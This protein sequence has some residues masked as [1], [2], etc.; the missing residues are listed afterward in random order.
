MSFV[1]YVFVYPWKPTVAMLNGKK[2]RINLRR[3]DMFNHQ[4][5]L[6]SQKLDSRLLVV[7]ALASS[8]GCNAKETI[9]PAAPDSVAIFGDSVMVLGDSV[10]LT[11]VLRKNGV[12]LAGSVKWQSDQYEIA[13][14]SDAGIVHSKARGLATISATSGTVRGQVR[15]R[16]LGVKAVSIDPSA[17]DLALGWPVT[18]SGRVDTDSGVPIKLEWKSSNTTTVVVTQSGVVTAVTPGVSYVTASAYGVS[19]SSTITV[20]SIPPL[21]FG[22]GDA[23]FALVPPG[24]FQMGGTLRTGE[25]PIRSVV[26]TRGLSV[27]RTEVTQA[28]WL[29]VMGFNPSPYRACGITC[30][31]TGISWQVAQTFI[32]R[33]NAREPGANYR[34]PTEAEWEYAARA[35]SVGDFGGSGTVSEMGWTS[36]NS[37]GLPKPAALKS[38]NGWGL[39]DMHG[40]AW[41]WVADWQSEQYD[42]ADTVDPK[43]LSFGT[44]KVLRGGVW[45]RSALDARSASRFGLDPSASNVGV[46]F[47]LVRNP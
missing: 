13:T 21:G 45:T 9:A 30:P 12:L 35:G 24:R 28:Q 23:Q 17:V 26:L 43:G 38:E 15:V 37:G 18:L 20:P 27:Q 10:A 1:V 31:I 32:E 39:F 44:R 40:N 14:V 47:R 34:L 7:F 8:F 46:G 3:G 6:S 2:F 42:R 11:A 41:E 36:E 19:G 25:G 5:V 33:L 22:F 29:D 16:V 4:G